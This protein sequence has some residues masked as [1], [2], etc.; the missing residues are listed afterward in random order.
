MFLFIF[1]ALPERI[2]IVRD[3][4][5]RRIASSAIAAANG[6]VDIVAIHRDF[7]WQL[8]AKFPET[9]SASKKSGLTLGKYRIANS[10]RMHQKMLFSF[11]TVVFARASSGRTISGKRQNGIISAVSGPV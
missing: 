5:S 11:S 1:R 6:T 7:F 4:L 2:I 10:Y 8:T 9:N 3:A